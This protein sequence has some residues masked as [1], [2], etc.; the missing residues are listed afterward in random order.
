M[1]CSYLKAQEPTN[2]KEVVVTSQTQLVKREIDRISYNVQ[3]DPDNKVQSVLEMLAKVPLIAVDG[4]NNIKL[5]GNGN[6]K[7][8]ING[9]P[10]SLTAR[11]P[12]EA[13][14]A[15]PAA[16]VARIEVITTPPAKYDAEG[17]AGII[18]IV[19][20]KQRQDGYNAIIGANYN[21]IVGMGQNLSLTVKQNKVGITANGYMYE[22]LQRT[23]T[24]SRERYTPGNSLQQRGTNTY[25]GIFGSGT[26]ELSYEPDSLH[27]FTGAISF[28]SSRD[29][30]NSVLID[31]H[32]SQLSNN[33][34][35][36]DNTL[37]ATFNY[38]KSFKGDKRKLLSFAYQFHHSPE[39]IT[40][41]IVYNADSYLQQNENLVNEHTI[42][43]DYSTPVQKLLIETGIKAILRN[44]QSVN[45]YH[46]QQHVYSAYQSY[47]INTPPL[48]IKAGIRFEYTYSFKDYQNWI[49]VISLQ[50]AFKNST[51]NLGFTRR[52]ERP[53]I[54]QLNPFTDKSN[55]QF[56]SSGNPDLH[57]VIQN[58][59]ELSFNSFTRLNY[60]LILSYQFVNN[61][62]E[63]VTSVVDTLSVIS[64]ENIGNN[65]SLRL[66]AG[67]N[68][69]LTP[70]LRIIFNT[71]A[72]MVWLKGSSGQFLFNNTGITVNG[73]VNLN[74]KI[75]NTWKATS[76]VYTTSSTIMLQGKTNAYTMHVTRL[77]KELFH[78]H[79]V[80]SLALSNPYSKYRYIRTTTSSPE[81]IQYN[82]QQRYYRTFSVSFSYSFGKLSGGIKKNK[83]GIKNDDVKVKKKEK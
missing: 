67:F 41:T 40:N 59:T 71:D 48:D 32:E 34:D 38:G 75:S 9:K 73:F 79:G 33:N 52:I 16:N 47:L 8:F 23:N 28:Y 35:T 46:Y 1:L 63:Q 26:T 58:S 6:F 60:H 82:S 74:Y 78:K 62:I 10:S 42:Q 31:E 68:Y 14:K 29:H 13:L 45:D 37:D 19:T 81:F 3:A 53:S 57:P 55:P 18:N 70:R 24:I 83:L 7:V 20:V 77:S 54:Q 5:K 22:D 66:N 49:P 43:G 69:N 39:W 21:R 12:K 51:L 2:L 30:S 61:N 4:D 80:V 72:G 36:R 64:Y 76:T 50:H 27:L 25:H 44:G 15:M 17:L 56:I 65:K 11:N